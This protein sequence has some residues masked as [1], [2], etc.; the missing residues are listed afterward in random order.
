MKYIFKNNKTIIGFGAVALAAFLWSLDGV[1]LRPQFYQFPASS[2]VFLEHFLGLVL[3][4]PIIFINWRIILKIQKKT[5]LALGWVSL[6]GGLLGTLMITE[7]FFAAFAGKVSLAT[8][9]ILQKLQPIF[10]LLMARVVLK[11]NL[12]RKF[13]FWAILAVGASYLLAFGKQGLS[14]GLFDLNNQA[15]W[16]AFL[17]AFSFG[18]STVFGKRLVNS[19]NF[20]L[21]TV[22]RFAL[23]TLLAGILV[24]I[25]GNYNIINEI[26]WK[27]WRLLF[28]IVLSSGA[29]AMYIYY[30]GLKKIPASFA[31]IAELFWPLSAIILD[32]IIN[33]NILTS[34]QWLATGILLF[35]FYKITL[36]SNNKNINAK[37][38]LIINKKQIL[39]NNQRF[40]FLEVVS[41]RVISGN[42]YGRKIGF[43]TANIRLS[44]KIIS[45]VYQGEVFV[46]N[47]KYLGA[48]FVGKKNKTLEVHLL[49]FKDDLYGEEIVVGLVD[50][51]RSIRKFKNKQKLVTQIK[52]DIQKIK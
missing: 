35:A 3:L 7:A 52:K 37:N 23:T 18:S 20:S 19:L 4:S 51:L 22:L 47:K 29:V 6:F 45:G 50:M 33:K 12:S 26:S 49:N 39:W 42:E 46:R 8:V 43:P 36:L 5:W 28:L 9:I 1:F 44:K 30:F 11:E 31:S 21:A 25:L 32:Y 13:Y 38:K 15:A 27:Y 24:L 16:F 17:A 48:V 2:I 34:W 14:L 10:A 41:G 40:N